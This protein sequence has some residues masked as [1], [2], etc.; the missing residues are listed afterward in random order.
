MPQR[1]VFHRTVRAALERDGWS[2]THDPLL[3]SFGTRRLFVDLGAEA[4]I[5][6]EKGLR[7]IA[8]EVKSFL[9]ESEMTELERALGQY[10]LYR[11]VLNRDEPDRVLYLAVTAEVYWKLFTDADARDLTA[12]QQIKLLVFDIEKGALLR[13]IE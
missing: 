13:W 6:A 10:A 4:P 5:A 7:K 9:G 12:A 3:L 11:F 2:V 1:D 8:L